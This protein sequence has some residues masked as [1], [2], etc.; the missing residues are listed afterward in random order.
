LVKR[1]SLTIWIDEKIYQQWHSLSEDDEDKGRSVVYLDIV[2]ETILMLKAV[3]GLP[4]RATISL[5]ESIINLMDLSLEV[6]H[7]STIS[8]RSK[9]L[10]IALK[11]LTL[12]MVK[13]NQL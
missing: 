8:R 5:V 1:E 11:P 4:Y 13:L 7:Y 9:Q 10:I 3:Y 12:K 6:P 2:I